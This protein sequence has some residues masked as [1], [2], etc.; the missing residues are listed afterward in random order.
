MSAG[1]FLRRVPTTRWWMLNFERRRIGGGT[2]EARIAE[3][4]VRRVRERANGVMRA[5]VVSV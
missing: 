1:P 2:G 4:Q 3:A 5:S